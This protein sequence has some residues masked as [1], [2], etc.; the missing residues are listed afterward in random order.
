MKNVART[1]FL[2]VVA[3]VVL[4]VAPVPPAAAQ[5]G[6][7]YAKMRQALMRENNTHL[8]AIGAFLKGN[9]N[10]KKAKALG[11]AGDVE[12]RAMALAANADRIHTLFAQKTSRD[13][14][15]GK[16]RAK[17]EIWADWKGFYAETQN[18]KKLAMSLEKAAASGDKQKIGAALKDI[19]QNACTSCHKKF[20][21]P[22]PK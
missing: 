8:K 1:A 3:A 7:D 18:L 15:P 16:T 13:D 12:F 19:G 21:G 9:K 11:T 2:G 20:R 10:P 6:E 17:H 22:K 14:L 4:T 5:S